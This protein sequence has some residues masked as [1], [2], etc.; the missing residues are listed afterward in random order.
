MFSLNLFNI[1]NSFIEI[2]IRKRITN[3]VME[4]S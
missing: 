4:V 2:Q 3:I 1:D